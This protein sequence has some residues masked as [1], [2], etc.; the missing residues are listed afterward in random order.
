MKAEN[1]VICL[2]LGRETLTEILGEEIQTIIYRNIKR[3]AFDKSEVLKL[4]TDI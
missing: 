3:W 4:L 1:E 2:A